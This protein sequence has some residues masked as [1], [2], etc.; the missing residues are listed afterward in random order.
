MK[1]REF[2][3]P[4]HRKRGTD[5]VGD[6]LD[7]VGYAGR[8]LFGFGELPREMVHAL[9]A[10]KSFARSILRSGLGHC[11]SSRRRPLALHLDVGIEA[12]AH[13]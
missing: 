8:L 13:E 12:A 4:G 11:A 9:H 1:R 7:L 3:R 2:K 6:A 5:E 10:V